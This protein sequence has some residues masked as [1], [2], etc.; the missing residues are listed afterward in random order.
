MDTLAA[1]FSDA[2]NFKLSVLPVLVTYL[3]FEIPALV[4]KYY[5]RFYTPIYFMFFPLGHTDQ[6]YA[7]YFNED[8]WYGVGETQTKEEKEAVRT[9]IIAT[10]I[11]SMIFSA[12]VAPW[13]TGFA[14]AFYLNHSQFQEFVA[15]LLIVKFLTLSY[16]IYNLRNV[17]FIY[18]SNS[19]GWVVLT[20]VFYLF[21]VWWGV[22]N[23]FQWTI[24]NHESIGIVPTIWKMLGFFYAEMFFSIGIVSAGTWALI[25]YYT[26]PT[27]ID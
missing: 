21:L 14:S 22:T 16:S 2:W 24:A 11:L 9:K 20:Y 27:Y 7:Q 18:K 6:L 25:R 4:R 3:I 26:K 1:I 8:D 17:S 13:A 5:R 23:A 10:S 12:V 15:F 19:L